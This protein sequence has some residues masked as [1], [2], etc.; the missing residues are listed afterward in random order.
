MQKL[1]SIQQAWLDHVNQASEQNISM[2]AY[3]SQENLSI[4]AFYTARTT[5]VNLGV[6]PS[7][8]SAQ[9]V[10]VTENVEN[11]K[12]NERSSSCQVTLLNGVVLDFS[13]VEIFSLIDKVS[14][15]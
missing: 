14:Q 10:L 13:D 15:L 7:K 5:L 3:A 2:A 6:L 8:H 4:K 9:L 11:K 12:F 1:T